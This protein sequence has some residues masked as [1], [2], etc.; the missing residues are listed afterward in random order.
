[1]LAQ[2]QK[3]EI[4][5]M[6]TN[7]K[8]ALAVLASASIGAAGGKAIHVQQVKT[9]PVYLVSE[10]DAITDFTAIK[11]YGERVPETLAPFNGHYHFVVGGGKTQG[12]DGEAPQGI[13][14]IQ[15][16]SAEQARA[17]YGSPAYQAIKPIRQ[18]AV[19]G[20]VFLVEGVVPQ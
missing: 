5:P 13:V 2:T 12:L 6:K 19:K 9:A 1:L 3:G 11:K 4:S 17:W 15:F 8:L 14:V 7:H 18:S 20:R 10:A 16:D